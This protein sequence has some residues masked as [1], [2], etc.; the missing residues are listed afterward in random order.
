[1]NV[2]AKFETDGPVNLGGLEPLRLSTDA[3]PEFP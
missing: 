2:R 3:S 1:M